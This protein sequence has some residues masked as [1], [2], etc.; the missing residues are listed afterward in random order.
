[1][2]SINR[3]VL[4]FGA[5]L[6]LLGVMGMVRAEL[7]LAR[8]EALAGRG[9]PGLGALREKAEALQEQSVADGQLSD[10][11]LK[12]GVISLPTDSF[13][14]GQEPMTQLQVGIQQAFPAGQTLKHRS[15]RTARLADAA[16]DSGDAR[17]LE[18]LKSVRQAWL[19]SYYWVQ[20]AHV[21][22][23]SLHLFDQLVV[24]TRAHYA[25]GKGNQQEVV[26]AELELERLK[27]REVKI[28]TREDQARAALG[29]WVGPERA[30]D[31]LPRDLPKL[32]P[33]FGHAELVKALEQH[34]LIQA[35]N[36]RVEAGDEGVALARQ[37]YKPSW[38]LG[39]SYGAR[40]GRNAP[41]GTSQAQ[42][43][44][45]VA[46]TW[47]AQ[48]GVSYPN[49]GVLNNQ[50]AV[51]GS[52]RADLF[53]V[54]LTMDLPLFTGNR[55]DRRLA[56]SRH[57]A[58]AAMRSR[59]N[60]LRELRHTL[61]D[62]YAAWRRAGE[63]LKHYRGALIPR[64]RQNSEAAL[65]AYQSERG[66]FDSLMRARIAELNTRLEALRLQVDQAKA[67]A[68]LLYLAGGAR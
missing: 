39:L 68:G 30:A 29:R 45:S 61:D 19:E 55:Q 38:M 67:Q 21:V 54:M 26:Q 49:Y 12:L 4:R 34:P 31:P 52:E 53:S 47:L 23:E 42:R 17:A 22:D 24:I 25:T 16:G 63:R 2:R 62:T 51:E 8:A 40:G 33:V 5:G 13:N 27:D 36:A 65:N 56:A 57:E 1:M 48:Q 37:A 10:P 50:L 59:D 9:E 44:L 14:L 58:V 20:A 3:F 41:P 66:D 64:A 43:A 15:R 60:Q 18:V 46:R 7:T 11:K 28:H 6:A 35:E 32:P